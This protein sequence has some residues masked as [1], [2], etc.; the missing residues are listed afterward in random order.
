[1]SLSLLRE[2]SYPSMVTRLSFFSSVWKDIWDGKGQG[3]CHFADVILSAA[4]REKSPK[5]QMARMRSR[6]GFWQWELLGRARHREGGPH[7]A[8]AAKSLSDKGSSAPLVSCFPKRKLQE[9]TKYRDETPCSYHPLNRKSTSHTGMYLT[10]S[11]KSYTGDL[12]LQLKW[13]MARWWRDMTVV[14]SPGAA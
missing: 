12:M 13:M 5:I 7:S 3:S 10:L 8:S 6:E 2:E 11:L 14:P 4:E 1:M 9:C